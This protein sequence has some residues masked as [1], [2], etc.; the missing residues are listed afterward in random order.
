VVYYANG[1]GGSNPQYGHVAVVKDVLDDGTFIEEGY[2]GLAA[3]NDHR[4]YTRKV[5]N[6]TPTAF[7]YVNK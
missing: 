1:A 2:N 5:S 3:P 6:N 7:L 4:Y